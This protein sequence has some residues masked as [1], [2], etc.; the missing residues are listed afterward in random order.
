MPSAADHITRAIAAD[1]GAV[2]FDAFMNM[3]LYGAEGFYNSGGRAGRR[4]DFITS[5]EVGPLFGVVLARAIDA[6]WVEM[7]SPDDF[8]IFDV[9]AGP[10]TLARSVLAAEPRCLHGDRSRYVCVETS[11]VQRESH[12]EGVTSLVALPEGELRGVV[13][14]NELL[15]NLAFRLLAFDGHW[16]ESWIA[17]SGGALVEVLRP[18]DPPPFAL[19]TRPVH[20]ARVPW[21]QA[22]G[23]WTVDVLS[24]LVGR[25]V[26]IDYAVRATAE[27]AG[28]PW[29]DWLRTYSG[30]E[31]GAH[32]LREVGGQDITTDV[33][34]DQLI[35][36][37]GEPDAVRS[38]DQFLRR[39]GI[40]ELVEEGRRVWDAE[41]SRPGLN[42]MRMRSRISESEAL[43]DPEGLGGFTV[44]EWVRV[45]E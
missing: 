16:R 24:R 36:V 22:A 6:W 23:E 42:A 27:L 43:L 1:G 28:R 44:L 33:C 4:G 18:C 8:R 20:A 11:A 14:A 7:G 26:V 17:A 21:Q 41:A 12:P 32:Y 30:Q 40:D 3:A 25:L 10:G 15:D 9:G 34:I 19:P 2:R 5:P 38:Q 35:S 29:R 45:E 31:R 39:W 37:C 13:F